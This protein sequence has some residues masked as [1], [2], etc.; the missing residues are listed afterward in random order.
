MSLIK[1]GAVVM[2]KYDIPSPKKEQYTLLFGN[3][4]KLLIPINV[5]KSVPYLKTKINAHRNMMGTEDIGIYSIVD[6][7]GKL[8][9]TRTFSKGEQSNN[10][11]PYHKN[12]Q[13][14]TVIYKRVYLY[15]P[16]GDLTDIECENKYPI[17]YYDAICNIDGTFATDLDLLKHLS[18]F[19]YRNPI[20]VFVKRQALVNMATYIPQ[21]KE[22]FINL[23]G[24]GEKLYNKCGEAFITEIRN[25]LAEKAIK[26]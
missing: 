24:I 23:A 19:L 14:P 15:D 4:I 11:A 20:P 9:Y 16:E 17:T 8:I 6:F 13:K 7:D 10:S 12:S 2:Y 25:Y 18:S 5:S 1:K 22:T 21:D 26:Q 3:D